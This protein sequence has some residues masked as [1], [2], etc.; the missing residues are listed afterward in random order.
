VRA[1]AEEAGRDAD[2]LIL[3]NSTAVAC[4]DDV[5]RPLVDEPEAI[6]DRLGAFR[7]YGVDHLLVVLDAKTAA[8]S[9]AATRALA[10]LMDAVR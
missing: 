8:G 4:T 10:D 7:D 1:N 9:L 6:V 2:S 3:V 5:D